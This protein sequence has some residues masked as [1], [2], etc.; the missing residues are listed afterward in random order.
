MLLTKEQ[1]LRDIAP[2]IHEWNNQESWWFGS[3]TKYSNAQH[4]YDCEVCFNEETNKTECLVY[5]LVEIPKTGKYSQAKLEI[6]KD[7]VFKFNIQHQLS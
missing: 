5:D 2:Y 7:T 4:G 6:N 1:V 3:I